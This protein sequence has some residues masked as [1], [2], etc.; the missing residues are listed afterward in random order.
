MPRFPSHRD[1]TPEWIKQYVENY[2]MGLGDTSG[3]V[4]PDPFANRTQ[5]DIEKPH[6]HLLSLMMRP[7]YFFFA[8]KWILNKTLPPYQLAILQELW[9]RPFPMLIGSRGMGKSFLLAVYA[10]M[11]ALF[12]QG[13]KIVIVG[14]AF[15]Q[16]KVVFDYCQEI[17]EHAPIL[18]DL[19]GNDKKNGPRRDVD[20]C[21][22]R[23]GDSIIIALPLGDGSKIRGQRASI[24][25]ADE[26]ASI[27]TEIFETVVRGFAAV[28]NNPVDKFLDQARNAAIKEL[29]LW[30]QLHEDL[31]AEAGMGNQTI[32]SGTAYYAFNH[33]Y[34]YWKRYKAI[35]ES[36]GDR[37]K[38]AEAFGGPDRVDP[39]LDWKDYCVI[40][41][42][43]TKLPAGMMDEKQIAQAKATVHSGTYL[44]EYGACVLP[45][46][47]V[48]TNVGAKEIQNVIPGD[49]VLTHRGR[50]RQAT[51]VYTRDYV[52]DIIAYR[53]L[54]YGGTVRV[55]P[56][57]P[58]WAGGE[59]W[60]PAS[61]VVTGNTSIANLVELN[62]TRVI[63]VRLRVQNY[64][65]T[66]GKLFPTPSQAKLTNEDLSLIRS[67]G[68]SSSVLAKRFSISVSAI[69]YARKDLRVPK[70]AIP[71]SI[72]LDYD[73][74]MVVGYYAAEGSIGADGRAVSFSLDGH[75]DTK[76]E[77]YVEQLSLAIERVFGF[78]PKVYHRSGVANVTI[79]QRLVGDL[80]KSICPGVSHTKV[81]D[82]DVLFSNADFLRGFVV[83]YWNG[84]GHLPVGDRSPTLA[85][86]VNESLL[87]QVRL[88][89]SYF[90]V[91][92]TMA[93]HMGQESVLRGKVISPRMVYTL[94]MNGDNARQFR[95][96]F[97]GEK[98]EGARASR[99]T[100]DG[101]R[102]IMPVVSHG[103]EAY[104]G[105]V[106]NLE[107]EDDHS[108]SLLNGTVHNCFATDSN[109]FY[110]RS[111]IESCVVGRPGRAV[112]H[113]SCGDIRFGAVLRGDP[114]RR[115]VFAVDP[116]S[117]RDNFSITVLECWEDHRRIVYGWTTTRKR[118]KAKLAAGLAD[119][120]DFYRYCARMIRFLLS[121]FPCL[122]IAIDS[123]GGGV[124]I[125]EALQD[126]EKLR[127]GERPI[128]PVIDPEDPKPSDDVSGDHILE[129]INF[130]D[131]KW[132][133]QA[134][135]GMKKDLEDKV[136]LFPEFD[137]AVVAL[138]LEDDKAAGRIST[139]TEGKIEKL[140]D[141]LEDAVM[142]IEDLKDELATIVHTQ[143]GTT[144]RDR[145]DTPETKLAGGKKGRLRKDRYSSLLM[146]NMVARTLQRTPKEA[147]YVAKGGF[148]K[149][150][151]GSGRG[152]RGPM[153]VGPS[154]W[155]EAG[156]SG[157]TQH[158]AAVKR[159]RR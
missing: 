69:D 77:A 85:N 80:I 152:S 40:R 88:A 114:K 27:P 99:L 91:S 12:E 76:L 105:P 68:E 44:M 93:G 61:E 78:S 23:L 48:T 107:V 128:L 144:M 123:Q 72:E 109:G 2:W 18:R 151:R 117:E 17:W 30:S 39:K 139:D 16:A 75:V 120:A 21:S 138:A 37:H 63:D 35:V 47:M 71:A 118:F 132:V 145:W 13:R 62:G 33:F 65:E 122:R 124:A 51:K 101:V 70:N 54:G 125:M 4:V 45:G 57:H 153:W 25:I 130:A 103:S 110:K 19:V 155:T 60:V 135:H 10:M 98:R 38:L 29:G 156:G 8:A 59:N 157:A 20:R 64:R 111:L 67:S 31:E 86:C 11:R 115:Y 24:V 9:V 147:E 131:G 6:V 43:V 92:A 137:P 41:V 84:D 129:I 82:P 148:A 134:N 34:E 49:Q 158:G 159:G 97:Y 95:D 58:Y 53:T 56:E 1:R 121:V 119:E 89:L 100:N 55:T 136:L 50:F 5:D 126:P 26:F 32:I 112:S 79:N 108:Y 96:V 22:L 74:G 133:S 142:E 150:L 7:E 141:T 83:G 3:L 104:C 116:A 140:Y 52:G 154:W 28:A 90:G 36:R 106:Y 113:P 66:N 87:C 15:R 149:D 46:T 143:V 42:P 94:A 81:I 102:T 14:A 73:F 146:A 127:P